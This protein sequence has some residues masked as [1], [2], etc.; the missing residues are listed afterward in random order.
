MVPALVAALLAASPTLVVTFDG[1]RPGRMQGEVSVELT[2]FRN[3]TTL[4]PGLE[5]DETTRFLVNDP[6]VVLE[7]RV[8]TRMLFDAVDAN[9][10]ADTVSLEE[11]TTAWLPMERVAEAW[12][13]PVLPEVTPMPLK[14]LVAAIKKKGPRFAARLSPEV[15]PWSLVHP[16]QSTHELRLVRVRGGKREVVKTLALH[17]AFGC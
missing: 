12:K 11:R 1:T 14:K 3:A 5:I 2:D 7:V 13:R 8:V 17:T 6:D 15:E 4:E 16:F 9:S 10:E